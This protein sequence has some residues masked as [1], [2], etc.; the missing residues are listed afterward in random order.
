ME[1]KKTSSR[2]REKLVH[3]RAVIS[4]DMSSML[5]SMREMVSVS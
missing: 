1:V 4:G 5:V 2:P 3:H